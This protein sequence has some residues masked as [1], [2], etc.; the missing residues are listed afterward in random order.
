MNRAWI[1]LTNVYLR[2]T[3][4]FG[5]PGI[6]LALAFPWLFSRMVGLSAD[7]SV[8]EQNPL[9]L[10]MNF[11]CIACC[12]TGLGAWAPL[13]D[14]M[15]GVGMRTLPMSNRSLGTFLWLVP[16]CVVAVGS[17]ALMFG[18]QVLYGA[19]WP[20]LTTVVCITVFCTLCMSLGFWVRDFRVYRVL[21]ALA[22]IAAWIVWFTGRFFPAGYRQ[23][24]VPWTQ[25]TLANCAVI[26]VTLEASDHSME[27]HALWKYTNSVLVYDERR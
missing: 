15:R 26:A 13:P 18:C 12:L 9:G 2:R 3:A 7:W 11:V 5:V 21:L 8:S 22:V 14:V 16:G 1:A 27:P 19:G 10:Y 6:A 20:I 24:L 23:P 25:F 4:M 17:L